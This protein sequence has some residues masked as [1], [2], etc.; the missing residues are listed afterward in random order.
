MD[1]IFYD[2]EVFKYDSLVVFKNFDNEIVGKFWNSDGFDGII[3]VI[4]NALLVG[5]NNYYYDD[6]IL[7]CMLRGNS[8]EN[9]KKVNDMLIAGGN[10]YVKVDQRI[11]SIDCFQQIDVSMPGLKKIEGNMGKMIKESSIPFTIDRALTEAEREEIFEYCSYD[12]TTT[13][14]VYKLRKHSYFDSKEKL[15]E[16]YGNDKAVR[17]NTTTI[18]A[19]LLLNKPLPKWSS[20]RVPEE[21]WRNENIPEEVWD[22]WEQ[23][24]NY[25][26][27]IKTK[28]RTITMF[29]NKIQ[30]GFGGL[31]GAYKKV[32]KFENVKLLDVASMYPNI[33]I[34]LNV[35]GSAT[36]KYRDLKEQRIAVKHKDKT[37]SD[38]LKLVLNSVYGNLKNQY[39]MLN[40]PR[41]S[42]TVC[43][44][45]QIA[46]FDL[47][48]QLHEKG[49][50]IVNI[51]TDGVAFADNGNDFKEVWK[52]WE[53]KY[54]LTLELDEFDSWI[55]KDVNNYIATRGN[56]IK[57]KGGECGKYH[58]D[59]YFSN[60][61]ARIL[62]IA[63]V[64]YLIKGVDILDTILSNTDKPYL[65][66]YILQAGR[67]YKGVFDEQGNKYNNINR[68]FACKKRYAD[69]KL[70]KKRQD[71]G[72]VNFPD[73][74]EYMKLWDKD[75]GDIED[76]DTWIDVNHYYQIVKK[77]L[78]SWEV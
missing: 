26:D 17:W 39:S 72:L 46:L 42:Q 76:L 11:H 7:T 27:N 51:N 60:N 14:E 37:L 49:C 74:P 34:N 67:T 21:L 10:S 19:N 58:V 35:L 57:V 6:K 31:H 25:G 41:A 20:L 70:F 55:Q 75:C 54:K 64:D 13:I 69:S 22:M 52:K 61:N 40:N 33:I 23:A 62:D 5:Y 29:D 3:E 56:Q 48:I 16:L 38:A 15:L 63:L 2:I 36:E 71:D 44:Y 53:R 73:V 68:V 24:N 78:K 47:C 50:K 1:L 77:R 4:E 45:G 65:Y 66:Q 32:C 8:Q 12:I 59:K 9:I 43:V 28:S 18:S 30:F